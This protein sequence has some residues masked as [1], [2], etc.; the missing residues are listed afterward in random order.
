LLQEFLRQF[1]DIAAMAVLTP[2]YSD[3]HNDD[4]FTR[5]PIENAV[6][7]TYGPDATVA[8]EGWVTSWYAELHLLRAAL[9]S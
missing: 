8:F 7:L 2:R 9:L 6:T 5:D 3:D 1:I 4:F